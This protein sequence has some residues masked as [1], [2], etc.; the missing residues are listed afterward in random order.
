M[1]Q[2]LRAIHLN[3]VLSLSPLFFHFPFLVTFIYPLPFPAT[4]YPISRVPILLRYHICRP[5]SILPCYSPFST[6][7][8]PGF[9]QSIPL[10]MPYSCTSHVHFPFPF[11]SSSSS[12]PR[13]SLSIP[14]LF[15][16][17]SPSRQLL[18]LLKVCG[19]SIVLSWRDVICLFLV[20]P[21]IPRTPSRLSIRCKLD[22]VV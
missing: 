9:F 13:P 15:N 22:S 8:S 21:T 18:S 4:S 5:T 1:V 11:D 10:P 20:R 19:L 16:H 12:L 3:E 7:T 14:L 6:S 2:Q 17:H